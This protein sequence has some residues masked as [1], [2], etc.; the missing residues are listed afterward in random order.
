MDTT[1]HQVHAAP[2]DMQDYTHEAPPDGRT[3]L[4]QERAR[5]EMGGRVRPELP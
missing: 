5:Y 4:E 3:E 1:M 2:K